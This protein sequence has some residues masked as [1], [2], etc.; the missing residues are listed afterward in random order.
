MSDIG[1]RRTNGRRNCELSARFFANL[2]LTEKSGSFMLCKTLKPPLG[3]IGVPGIGSFDVVF[4]A[5]HKIL[6]PSRCSRGTHAADY[7]LRLSASLE[8]TTLEP[9]RFSRGTDVA[10]YRNRLS[11]TLEPLNRQPLNLRASPA[12]LTLPNYRNRPF[13]TLEPLNRQPLNLKIGCFFARG[14]VYFP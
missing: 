2:F 7:N 9:S 6:T 3:T 12:G 10:N 13:A 1:R 4:F 8:P 14:V 11:A 5:R